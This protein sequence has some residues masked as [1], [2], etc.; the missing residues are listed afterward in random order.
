M[1]SVFLGRELGA[2]FS[3]NEI[4]ELRLSPFELARLILGLHPV[5]NLAGLP[6]RYY[7][8]WKREG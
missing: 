2:L 3:G 7:R 4:P 5:C 6:F 8:R 1:V